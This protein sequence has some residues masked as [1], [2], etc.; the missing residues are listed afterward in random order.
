MNE[1]F[2]EKWQTYQSKPTY[3]KACKY[4][5]GM[6]NGWIIFIDSEEFG[7]DEIIFNSKDEAY[8]YYL[9]KPIQKIVN[10]KTNKEEEYI[11]DYTEPVPCI[12]RTETRKEESFGTEWEEKYFELIESDSWIVDYGGGYISVYS[13]DYLKKEYILSENSF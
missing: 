4:E 5:E 3:I 10:C 11:V 7:S 9:T 1:L 2:N 6:E 13:E 8:Q 12:W